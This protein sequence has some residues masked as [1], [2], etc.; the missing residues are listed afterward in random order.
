MAEEGRFELPIPFGMLAFQA[1]A[2]GHYATPPDVEMCAEDSET[3]ENMQ[4][5]G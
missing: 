1:S 4:G 5:F 2:L 3:R